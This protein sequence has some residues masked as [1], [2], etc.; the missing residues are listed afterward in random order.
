MCKAQVA[1][2]LMLGAIWLAPALARAQTA[3]ALQISMSAALYPA[4]DPAITN[5]VVRG[6]SGSPLQV[7]VVAPSGTQLSVDGQP[8]QTGSFTSSVSLSEGQSFSMVVNAQGA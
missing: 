4:F 2:R 5:Y 1:A 6:A 3:T 8:F 7:S